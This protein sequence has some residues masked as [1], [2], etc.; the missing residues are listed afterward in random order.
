M[1]ALREFKN[2][3]A[4]ISPDIV[5]VLRCLGEDAITAYAQVELRHRTLSR[6]ADT[7]LNEGLRPTNTAATPN[8]K[9]VDF[10]ARLFKFKGF[11][12]PDNLRKFNRYV[13]G[14]VDNR[15]PGNFFYEVTDTDTDNDYGIPERML[16]LGTEM[17]YVTAM[18]D[19]FD[20]AER[21]I[22]HGIFE[23]YH[24]F[25]YG[26]NGSISTFTVNPFSP[27]VINQRLQQF[28]DLDIEAIPV[29]QAIVFLQRPRRQFEGVYIPGEIPPEDLKLLDHTKPI[30]F[31]DLI[32]PTIDPTRS[33]F[34]HTPSHLRR[35]M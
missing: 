17:R 32:A 30:P 35:T 16:I 29:E 12:H 2:Q 26:A 9:D 13:K 23:R 14:Q 34:F 8:T 20:P 10:A 11:Y 25:I 15:P 18:E 5:R 3:E 21:K 33:R 1:N 6:F 27:P 4:Y 7:I 28:G 22:A 31:T 24:D 19:V